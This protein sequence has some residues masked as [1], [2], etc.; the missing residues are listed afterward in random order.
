M[1]KSI[2]VSLAI[3]ALLATSVLAFE[4][5]SLRSADKDIRL[6]INSNGEKGQG[7]VELKIGNIKYTYSLKQT[8][9]YGDWIQYSAKVT[10]INTETRKVNRYETQ[11]YGYLYQGCNAD[12]FY[13]SEIGYIQVK[14]LR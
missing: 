6:N 10:T 8:Q 5:F 13:L 2:V 4:D 9:R 11:M 14:N 1:K 12:W 3:L 7:S